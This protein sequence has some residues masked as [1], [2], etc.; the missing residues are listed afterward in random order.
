MRSFSFLHHKE[1]TGSLFVGQ[2]WWLATHQTKLTHLGDPFQNEFPIFY[3]LLLVPGS[4]QLML[5]DHVF[6]PPPPLPPPLIKKTKCRPMCTCPQTIFF[7]IFVSDGHCWICAAVGFHICRM[8]WNSDA[9]S[10]SEWTNSSYQKIR[11]WPSPEFPTWMLIRVWQESN[12]TVWTP[13]SSPSPST[14]L[15]KYDFSGSLELPSVSGILIQ[16]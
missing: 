12:R 2:L 8:R 5:M 15:S 14:I 16:L 7:P 3:G 1:C 4:K 11:D 6:T 10:D 9:S 13:S